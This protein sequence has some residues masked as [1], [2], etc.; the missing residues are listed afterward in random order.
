MK[1]IDNLFTDQAFSNRKNC[2]VRVLKMWG[3]GKT[4]KRI[5]S[6]VWLWDEMK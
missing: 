6:R 1:E 4:R 2:S 5:N 3:G